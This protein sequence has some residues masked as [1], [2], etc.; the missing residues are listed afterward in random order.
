MGKDKISAAYTGCYVFM[1]H[2]CIF[3]GNSH[4]ANVWTMRHLITPKPEPE[5]RSLDCCISLSRVCLSASYQNNKPHDFQ[6]G[7]FFA[8]FSPPVPP[9]PTCTV[10]RNTCSSRTCGEVRHSVLPTIRSLG[11]GWVISPCFPIVV[12][13]RVT[14]RP[15]HR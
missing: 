13:F 5:C 2:N 11:L 12:S 9:R 1:L 4:D 8:S 7:A 3:S 6:K 10:I 14:G 15:I